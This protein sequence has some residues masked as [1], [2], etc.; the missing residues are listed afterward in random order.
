MAY[1][2]IEVWN[3]AEP[4]DRQKAKY[5][6]QELR[7][8]KTYLTCIPSIVLSANATMAQDQT[9]NSAGS[10]YDHTSATAHT[11]TVPANATVPFR[12][13]TSVNLFNDVGAGV[14]TVAKEAGVTLI[15]AGEG[16]MTSIAVAAAGA[17]MITKRAENRWFVTG[18]GLTG[19]P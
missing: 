3:N 1:P 7:A 13:G 10:G 8:I 5:G 6:A 16:E 17:C 4:T 9:T 19:T 12:V 14:V 2:P 18:V 11:L 15:L